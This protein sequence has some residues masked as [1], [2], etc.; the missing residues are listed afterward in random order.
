M[1]KVVGAYLDGVQDLLP[2]SKVVAATW[3]VGF[4]TWPRIS[5]YSM[6]LDLACFG[7][8]SVDWIFG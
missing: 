3:L 1:Q 5:S 6:V 2:H 7:T 4:T 8:C